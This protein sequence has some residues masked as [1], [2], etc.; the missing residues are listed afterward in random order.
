MP[1]I[2]ALIL[3]S[4]WD[5]GP[6]MFIFLAG[7]QG[8]AR[9]YY[10]AVEID[11]GNPWHKMRHATIPMV[12]P[13]ILFNLI[14]SVIGTMQTFVQAYVMTEGGPDDAS[15]LYVL[16]HFLGPLISLDDSRGF[17][18]A[19]GL[20]EFTGLYTSQWHLLMAASTVAIAPVLV[21]FLFAQRSF[22]EGITLTGIKGL[23]GRAV[24][25]TEERLRP[26]PELDFKA[27]DT[28][29]LIPVSG[30]QPDRTGEG[31]RGDHQVVCPDRTALAAQQRPDHPVM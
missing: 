6:M 21:L 31:D 10:E 11:G 4:M 9:Q 14:P 29:E 27:G 8:V 19:L 18:L 28:G 23:R 24:R 25:A 3:M 26:L 2:P 17:T 13:T 20:A 1:V 12:T 22:I 30:D 16:Y 7:L 5:I 15:L